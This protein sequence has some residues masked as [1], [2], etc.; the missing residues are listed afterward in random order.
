MIHSNAATAVAALP[1]PMR[2]PFLH[3]F[4]MCV[5]IGIERHRTN[6][7]DSPAANN[8]ANRLDHRRMLV[9]VTGKNHALRLPGVIE[10]SASLFR[11][12]GQRLLTKNVNAAGQ[13]GMR[14]SG[15]IVRRSRNIHEVE[16]R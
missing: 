3:T 7:S 13:G 4:C 11:R 6:P 16:M 2:V 14:N 9:I 1:A 12:T 15:M 8:F 10:Q 5:S